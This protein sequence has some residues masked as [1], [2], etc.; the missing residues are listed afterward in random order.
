MHH[1]AIRQQRNNAITF[2]RTFHD[3]KELYSR[4][5]V[6]LCVYYHLSTITHE[7][8]TGTKP[9]SSFYCAIV[10]INNKMNKHFK[11]KKFGLNYKNLLKSIK[12]WLNEIV[13]MTYIFLPFCRIT[14]QKPLSTVCGFIENLMDKKTGAELSYQEFARKPSESGDC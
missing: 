14:Q 8:Q 7:Q 9:I 5:S 2:N 6:F 13:K 1:T 10:Q 4:F 12:T 3:F 11:P